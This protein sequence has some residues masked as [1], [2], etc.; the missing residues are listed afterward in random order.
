MKQ[1][2]RKRITLINAMIKR[3]LNGSFKKIKSFSVLFSRFTFQKNALYSVL[4]A[5]L[6]SASYCLSSAFCEYLPNNK[7]NSIVEIAKNDYETDNI[8]FVI[9]P[10]KLVNVDVMTYRMNEWT[11][12]MRDLYS[13]QDFIDVYMSEWNGM[14]SPGSVKYS[15]NQTDYENISFLIMPKSTY[16]RSEWINN[17]I[18]IIYPETGQIKMHNSPN[19]IYITKKYADY[20]ISLEEGV[21]PGDYS[22]LFQNGKT[23]SIPYSWTYKQN[24]KIYPPRLY[25][26]FYTISGIIN[27]NCAKYIEYKNLFGDFFICNELLTLPIPSIT[28]FHSTKNNRYLRNILGVA[29]KTYKYEATTSTVNSS[30]GNLLFEY[31]ISIFDKLNSIDS[32]KNIDYEPSPIQQKCDSV[33][34]VYAYKQN[35]VYMLIFGLSSIIS[36]IAS[37]CFLT[38]LIKNNHGVSTKFIVVYMLILVTLSILLG[39]GIRLLFR[40]FAKGMNILSFSNFAVGLAIIF[41]TVLYFSAGIISNNKIKKLPH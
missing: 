41:L 20:L 10:H 38:I 36:I 19:E 30:S 29:D 25:D 1:W 27:E 6:I 28:A 18:E 31:R 32:L 13:D 7:T 39:F 12:K 23:F 15:K 17:D 35:I 2:L 4:S 5:L 26:V 40:L 11:T 34:D 24:D 22:S 33:Y 14:Y 21:E 8:N 3:F 16:T 37:I 9:Y